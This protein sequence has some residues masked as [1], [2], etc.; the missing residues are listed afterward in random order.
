M[1]GNN[2][3]GFTL[4]EVIIA[5]GMMGAV[6]LLSMR[7]NSNTINQQKELMQKMIIETSYSDIHNLL[8]DTQSC[9]HSLKGVEVPPEG[10]LLDIKNRQDKTVYFSGELNT[11]RNKL[12]N[13]VELT[14]IFLSH[15]E[16]RVLKMGALEKLK[17]ELTYIKKRKTGSQQIKKHMS[18]LVET[19]GA[20]TRNPRSISH[21]YDPQSLSITNIKKAFCELDLKGSYN[22][23]L[24]CQ[25]GSIGFIPQEEPPPC[26]YENIGSF[27][28]DKRMQVL[29][30]CTTTGWKESFQKIAMQNSNSMGQAQKMMNP[31]M[32][33]NLGNT[34]DF[35]KIKL[36]D[37]AALEKQ[38]KTMME[39]LDKNLQCPAGIEK[40][41]SIAMC[42]PSSHPK[43][44]SQLGCCQNSRGEQKC[45][46]K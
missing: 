11:Q 41:H 26:E 31:M 5:C 21:C 42:C 7:I 15:P 35:S 4:T 3:K 46:L 25:V 10:L 6:A 28:F 24:G 12:G 34:Q 40:Y 9:N 2:Q 33:N 13:D 30:H 20:M 19:A 39:T 23:I 17:L 29:K 18:F 8:Y 45:L 14:E 22:E 44:G 32:F 16:A 27:Y 43:R 36:K 1:I 37:K 38:L